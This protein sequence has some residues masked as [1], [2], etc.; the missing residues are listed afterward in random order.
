MR[1][2]AFLNAGIKIIVTDLRHEEPLSETLH[3]EGGLKSY[4]EYINERKHCDMLHDDIIY[5]KGQKGDMTAEIAMQYNT[6]YDEMIIRF[7]NNMAA[8]TKRASKRR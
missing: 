3:Y 1:E 7:A 4:V 2:Q 8:C 6:A 5:I